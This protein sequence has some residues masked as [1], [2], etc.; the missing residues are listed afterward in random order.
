MEAG[1]EKRIQWVDTV[2]GTGILLI[3]LALSMRP[4]MRDAQIW[5]R[6]IYD[7][8]CS[9]TMGMFFVISGYT[10]RLSETGRPQNRARFA[11][12]KVRS[13]L[14][15]FFG[16]A[17]L[18]YAAFQ[19]AM[20]VPLTGRILE[21]SSYTGC[22]IMEYLNLTL[23]YD[24]PYAAHLWFI[25]ILFTVFGKRTDVWYLECLRQCLWLFVR[26]AFIWVLM[27]CSKKI[28]GQAWLARFGKNSFY[29]YLLH[30]PFCCG[31]IALVL[32]GKMHLP[33]PLVCSACIVCSLLIPL[34]IIKAVRMLRPHVF[35]GI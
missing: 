6:W 19:I 15:P 11:R 14:V 32:Y 10:Y 5:C 22:S 7:F 28:P 35:Q 34:S 1:A 26:F 18:I 12:K 23:F 21:H 33:I 16:Y 31:F 20:Q 2:K 29:I 4:E 13:L 17:I 25:W 3:V 9:F 8:I 30:Q 24:S 27:V